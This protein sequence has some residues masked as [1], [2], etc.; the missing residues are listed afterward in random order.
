MIRTVTIITVASF[1]LSLVCLIVAMTLAG[2]ELISEG[3][4]GGALSHFSWGN[5]RHS[6]GFSHTRTFDGP[7]TTKELPWRGGDHLMVYIPADV[8][9]TQADGPPRLIVH[10]PQDALDSL[11]LDSNAILPKVVHGG[12]SAGGAFH[13]AG[14]SIELTAPKVTSFDLQGGGKLD[15]RNYRQDR[16]RIMMSGGD[17]DVTADGAAKRVDLMLAGAG[18]ADLSRFVTSEA[19]VTVSGSGTAK[20]APKDWAKLD[21]SGSGQVNL[22]SHPKHLETN[23]SG[24]G[25]VDQGQGEDSPP[26]APETSRKSGK[27]V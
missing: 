1:V 27:P 12:D 18:E 23:I 20:I 3:A 5:G 17:G 22:L 13:D 6:V 15:I 19:A 2:P 8:T 14:V 16:L 11:N 10:G 4:W 21:V 26:S 24:S 7:Q 9:F 25:H